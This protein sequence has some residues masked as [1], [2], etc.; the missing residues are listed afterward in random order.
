MSTL[1]SGVILALRIGAT[2]QDPVA[3]IHAEFGVQ[4]QEVRARHA[5][6]LAAHGHQL[7][8]E[9]RGVAAPA[10]DGEIRCGLT[11]RRG[12]YDQ[13]RFF[14]PRLERHVRAGEG[15]SEVVARVGLRV[16]GHRVLRVGYHQS[17]RI[18]KR[19]VEAQR[20][21]LVEPRID[22]PP[23]NVVDVDDDTA[24]ARPKTRR[25]AKILGDLRIEP[26]LLQDA[27][28]EDR[29]GRA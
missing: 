2:A 26:A 11:Q 9:Q 23:P 13:S 25:I 16:A 14:P 5:A 4:R 24:A 1:E 22:P 12:W 7:V 8:V 6:R 27:R 21:V 20:A 18:Q 15:L 17:G 28:I 10:V 19:A 29:I 3:S